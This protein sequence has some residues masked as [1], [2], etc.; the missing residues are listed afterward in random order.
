MAGVALVLSML[1][2]LC[3][4]P[5]KAPPCVSTRLLVHRMSNRFHGLSAR[6]VERFCVQIIKE[7]IEW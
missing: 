7:K 5:E 3:S 2:I 4:D 1:T 6:S